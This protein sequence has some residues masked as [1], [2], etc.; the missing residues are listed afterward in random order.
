MTANGILGISTLFHDCGAGCADSAQI[1]KFYFSC[2][3]SSCS[4]TS[5]SLDEQILNPVSQLSRDNN[6]TI[7]Q[8]P[9]VPDGGALGVAGSLIFGIGT[10]SDNSLGTAQVLRSTESGR[11]TTSYKGGTFPESFIDSGST[12]LTFQDSTIPLCSNLPDYCP[13]SIEA[14]SASNVGS[15]GASAAVAFKVGNA[16]NLSSDR[17]FAQSDRAAPLSRLNNPVFATSFD[18]GLPFF[19]GRSVFV[20]VDGRFTPVGPGPFYAY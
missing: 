20:A 5:V 14:L 19:F 9:S 2:T 8:L 6:G 4:S 18:W 7:L 15:D 1:N 13:P 16:D 3:V 11:I 12:E 10:Q 17:T